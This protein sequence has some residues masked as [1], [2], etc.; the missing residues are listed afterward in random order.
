MKAVIQFAKIH[1][2][3]D[4]SRLAFIGYSFSGNLGMQ[5]LSNEGLAGEFQAVAALNPPMERTFLEMA[6]D[7]VS[8][9]RP[10]FLPISGSDIKE[11]QIKWFQSFGRPIAI[12]AAQAI[13][14]MVVYGRRDPYIPRDFSRI[15]ALRETG[16]RVESDPDEAHQFLG[17]A[18]FKVFGDFVDHI[19]S[20][21]RLVPSRGFKSSEAPVVQGRSEA[22]AKRSGKEMGISSASHLD[23]RIQRIFSDPRIREEVKRLSGEDIRPETAFKLGEAIGIFNM[24]YSRFVLIAMLRALRVAYG[25]MR[26][27]I[28]PPYLKAILENFRSKGIPLRTRGEAAGGQIYFYDHVPTEPEM[29]ALVFTNALH[30]SKRAAAEVVIYPRQPLA[31]EALEQL[32][33]YKSKMEKIQDV[34]GRPLKINF[35]HDG[36]IRKTKDHIQKVTAQLRNRFGG[37]HVVVTTGKEFSD[38]LSMEEPTIAAAL[39]GLKQVRYETPKVSALYAPLYSS[40][41]ALSQR[42]YEALS[43]FE[44][45]IL[46]RETPFLYQASFER[47]PGNFY[48]AW[49]FAE[50][51][52]L[53]ILKQAA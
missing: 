33:E 4:I 29:A 44:R 41:Q 46:E 47:V 42:D 2:E 52:I 30:P 36:Q 13:K 50:A 39:Y 3:I 45:L 1:P 10:Y 49:L 19:D 17:D 12:P 48:Q 21:F 25:Q 8:K 31:P 35:F 18:M 51:H 34:K 27:E 15:E 20:R 28:I 5:I 9:A 53:Q 23:A 14:L 24:K 37:E 26:Q 43:E 6:D 32:T 11:E 22:R 16:A 40:A 38:W 7:L